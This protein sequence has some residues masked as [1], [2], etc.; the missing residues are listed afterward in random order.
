MGMLY[1]RLLIVLN[2]ENQDSIYYHIAITTLQHIEEINSLSIGELAELCAVSKS[3]ISKFVRY[4]GYEDFAD[5]RYAT[6][7]RDNKYGYSFS[8]VNNVMH[9]M[10]EHS[11]DAFIQTVQRDIAAT[12]QVLDWR[13]VDRL[14]EDLAGHQYVAAFGLLFSE[15]AAMDLQSKLAY[16]KKFIVTNIN[17]LKQDRYIQNTG[18]DT[19]II[20]FS[21]SGEFLDKYSQIADFADKR[22]CSRAKA[23]IV[24][25]TSNPKVE[26]DPRVA[27]CVRYQKT[28]ELCTHRIVYAA[29]TDIIAYKYREYMKASRQ[30][31]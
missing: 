1:N 28:S 14:A 17:D 26:K 10:E 24:V 22:A 6:V 7:F 21:D 30:L 4:I 16:N 13:A 15:T 27:Y 5:F 3:T 12:Y 31:P 20:I 29:L 19:L 8:Y 2:E 9:Y 23:K 25:I 18:Q 11:L